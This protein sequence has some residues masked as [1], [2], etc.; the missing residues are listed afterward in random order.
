MPLKIYNTLTGKKE[1]FV[2]LE[3]GRV[4][5]YACGVTV[6]DLCHIGHSRS[7]FTFELVK[8]YLAYKGYD[9]RFVR[10]ITDID[11]KIIDRA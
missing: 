6:Y 2:S 10:N 5:M 8:R 4:K 11:D 7:L 1:E 9:V 3:P